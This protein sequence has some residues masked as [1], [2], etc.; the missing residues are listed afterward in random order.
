MCTLEHGLF[1]GRWVQMSQVTPPADVVSGQMVLAGAPLGTLTLP[2]PLRLVE[3][4]EPLG[5]GQAALNTALCVAPGQTVAQ[6][7]VLASLPGRWRRRTV[8]APCAG[9]VQ[10]VAE[11]C[12][13]LRATP[14][15]RAVVAPLAGQVLDVSSDGKITLRVSGTRVHCVWASGGQASGPLVMVSAPG[16]ELTWQHVGRQLAGA[17]LVGGRL[18][19]ERAVRRA[20]QFGLAGLVVGSVTPLQSQRCAPGLPILATEGLGDLAMS[21][22]VHAALAELAGQVAHLSAAEDTGAPWM[23]IAH[24]MAASAQSAAGPGL[25]VGARVR[26]TRAPYLG[27][28]GEI[29]DI[30]TAARRTALGTLCEGALVALSSGQRVFVPWVNLERIA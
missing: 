17:V 16:D 7:E 5:I 27:Q 19:D 28:S 24:D 3:L 20:R 23:A 26:L 29:V 12:L 13:L 30:P 15:T 14:L 9:T 10:A 8:V 6:G 18:R 21:A 2:G 25:A 22:A 1:I 4:A 11:G